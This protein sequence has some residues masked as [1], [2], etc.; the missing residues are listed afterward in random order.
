MK[1]NRVLTGSLCALGCEVL[2]GLSYLFTKQT[3]ETASPLALLGWRFVV[4]LAAMSLCVALG[5]IPVRL[6]GRQL[7]PLLRVAL[8]C[9]CLYFIGETVGIRETT[10][11]ESG[12]FL[13]CV[14]ALS[15]LASTV[16]LKKKPTKRQIIGILVTFLGVMTTVVAVGLSS[17]LSPVGYAALM[18]AVVAYALYSVFVDLAADYT[19]AEITYVMLCSGAAFYGLLALGEAAAHGALSEL[20]TLPARSGTFRTAVL[21]QGIGCSVA[22]FFLSN[23]AI[24]KIGVNKASS[25]IGVSTIVSILAGALALGEPLSVGQIV[26]AAVIV[27]GVYTANKA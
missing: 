20:L 18:L 1:D 23:A 13:A 16:I 27:A 19:G 25:F 11:T 26:G 5:F 2:Y 17:S 7:G 14:P 10:V 4:A 9:P 15:L 21:Y 24:A 8:F 3:A 12:V 6:K 22:A